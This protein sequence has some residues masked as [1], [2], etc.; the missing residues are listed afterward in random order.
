MERTQSLLTELGDHDQGMPRGWPQQRAGLS[1][2]KVMDP[3]EI[4]TKVPHIDLDRIDL[5][6]PQRVRLTS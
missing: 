6:T 4:A 5:A 2:A 1:P 3:L